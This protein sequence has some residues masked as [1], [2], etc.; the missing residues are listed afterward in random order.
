MTGGISTTAVPVDA[1]T[2]CDR[3]SKNTIGTFARDRHPLVFVHGWTARGDSME[4]TW[5]RIRDRM[6]D[7][8][9]AR[10]F[11]YEKANTDW[12]ASPRVAACLADYLV[13]VSQAHRETGGNGRVYVVAHSMGGLATRFATAPSYGGAPAGDVVA[14]LTTI[15]TPHLG[16]PFGNTTK[17]EWW[18]WVNE[19]DDENP[20][21]DRTSDAARCLALHDRDRPLPNG[22]DIAPYLP[23]GVALGQISGTNVVRRTLFGI[24]L[25]DIDLRSDGVVSVDSATGY[26][27]DSG[28][29]G[30]SAPRMSGT[31]LK[32]VS[33]TVTSDQTMEL[34]R[35]FRGGN[36]PASLIVAQLKAL[37]LLANDSALLDQ[38][39]TGE[40]GPHLTA[41]LIVAALTYPC[42]H[43]ALLTQSNSI[44]AVVESL[45][46]QLRT[47]AEPKK[48]TL[49][50]FDRTG[51]PAPGWTVAAQ[52]TGPVDCRF[53]IASVSAVDDDIMACSPTPAS[54]DA[55]VTT[56]TSALCLVD[57]FS[58]EIVRN[59]LSGSDSKPAIAPQSAVPIALV[60]DDGTQCRRRLGGS[61]PS[62]E[63]EP[64]Y[65][66][67]YFCS[68]GSKFE[69]VWG[70]RGSDGFAK[71]A[72]GWTV[73]VGSERGPL[74]KHRVAEVF[75]V[76][77][78]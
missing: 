61:W 8:F 3:P 49:R 22:C 25:Y 23:T 67:Y 7:T 5:H 14:G 15:A 44:D 24:T 11:D 65:V 42:S 47:S 40:L 63:A 4:D 9:E 69:A 10:M 33:C 66:G 73:E 78:A 62:P 77:L 48:T 26:L 56:S 2:R 41:M 60:L 52:S 71:G 72:D 75:Y 30:Q 45:R 53:G 31:Y 32:D 16:S 20:L 68:I 12:A 38:I 37:S 76:G 58:T 74:R 59:V 35:S 54:A 55:C 19:L 21:P 70:A 36:L 46:A 13:A 50:P 27:P 64:D 17:G 39:A 28:P 29:P 18:E 1:A 43:G 57:P 34:L 51:N 6:P